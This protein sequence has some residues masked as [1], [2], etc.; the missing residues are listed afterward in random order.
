MV[1]ITYVALLTG[2][3][4][5][6]WGAAQSF[7]Q[8][9]PQ[10]YMKPQA[11]VVTQV[12][13]GTTAAQ[14]GI[15]V[16]DVIVRVDGYPIRSLTDLQYRLAKAGPVAELDLIDVRTGW[17]NP[18]TVYPRHGRIGVDVRPTSLEA[19]RPVRPVRPINPPWVPGVR[20][21]PPPGK[22]GNGDVHIQPVP[23]PRPIPG[24]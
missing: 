6:I 4:L 20:P 3:G 7:A 11:V 19:E 16:G 14:Q 18:V 10:T 1:H 21:M 2:L 8:G 15:E 22:P 9:G 12:I 23:T 17:Q 13:P 5:T 24:R